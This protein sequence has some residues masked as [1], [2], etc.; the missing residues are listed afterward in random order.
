MVSERL[1]F[2]LGDVKTWKGL[3]VTGGLGLFS[4]VL[5]L[6]L[7]YRAHTSF[8]KPAMISVEVDTVGN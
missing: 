5:D 8:D 7:H 4:F 3:K 1:G 2:S 6:F